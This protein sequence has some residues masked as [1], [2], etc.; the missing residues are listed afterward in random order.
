MSPDRIRAAARVLAAARAAYT[1][2]GPSIAELADR[3]RR[4]RAEARAQ[5]AAR[6]AVA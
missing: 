3:I 4:H 1:P 2:G 5:S 6:S